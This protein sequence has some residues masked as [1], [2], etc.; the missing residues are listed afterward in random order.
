MIRDLASL[1]APVSE[2][3]FLGHFL[4]KKRLH[5][6]SDDPAR[7]APLFAWTKINH[8]IQADV[9]PPDRFRVARS[10]VD[11]LPTMYRYK[12]G[13]QQLR[14][15]ALQA[16]LPQGVSLV[17]NGVSDLVPEIGRLTDAIERR[18]GHRSWVNAYL[19][20]GRGSALKAH[21]DEHDVLVLQI[22][23]KKRWRSVGTPVPFPV[24]KHNAGNDLGTEVVWEGL[25]EPGDLLYLPRGEVHEAVVEE[26]SSVHVTFGIQTLS[27]IN[28]LGWIAELAA[29][30]EVARSDLTRAAGDAALRKHEARVKERLHAL[31][32]STSLAAYL[33]S[34]DSKRKPRPLF[35]LGLTETLNPTTI[36]VPALR[37]R[38]PIPIEP[39]GE[40]PVVVGGE[41][42]RLS[43]VARRILDLL[44]SCNETTVAD[45]AAALGA[46]VA[47]S[48]LR[49]TLVDL[50]KAG[51]LGLES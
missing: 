24:A 16:L 33:D 22:H 46:G 5:V 8:L 9:L 37:R 48:A 47:E 14:A 38:V 13:A 18:L 29:R 7:A 31:I 2:E 17:I 34:E 44:F 21:W 23:G 39:E 49:S 42:H 1:L 6:K 43:A 3:D 11:L 35:S 50:S 51:L 25:L 36:I 40:I 26:K 41:T 20:F 27:A 19:S 12:D 32:D 4:E 15:G 28:F 10:N 30:H 45:L